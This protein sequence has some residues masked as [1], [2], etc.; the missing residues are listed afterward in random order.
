MA[1]AHERTAAECTQAI[2]ACELGHLEALHSILG[3]V[4]V[5]PSDMQWVPR[6]LTGAAKGDH[7]PILKWGL[8]VLPSLGMSLPDFRTHVLRDIQV[9]GPVDILKW[10][11]EVFPDDMVAHAPTMFQSAVSFGHYECMVAL[12]AW[13]QDVRARGVKVESLDM[14]RALFSAVAHHQVTRFLL[15]DHKVDPCD[16]AKAEREA[17]ARTSPS[18]AAQSAVPWALQR[19]RLALIKWVYAHMPEGVD[20]NRDGGALWRLT[21]PAKGLAE[22]EEVNWKDVQQWMVSEGATPVEPSSSCSSTAARPLH[23]PDDMWEAIKERT[24]TMTDHDMGA[25]GWTV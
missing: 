5:S 7:L 20:I 12:Y 22:Q 9:Y 25:L 19:G 23:G 18:V 11:L 10:V 3:T 15:E 2:N 13:V 1:Q 21:L 6:G 4:P 8:S 14:E 24:A 17:A 16:K